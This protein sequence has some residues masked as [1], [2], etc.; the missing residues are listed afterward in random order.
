MHA[1]SARIQFCGTSYFPAAYR[2]FPDR[3]V[4][5]LREPDD[6]RPPRRQFHRNTADVMSADCIDHVIDAVFSLEDIGDVASIMRVLEAN[7]S[8]AHAC[9]RRTG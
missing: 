4:G 2:I 3:P 6:Q 8:R 7:I 1:R 9:E 5:R